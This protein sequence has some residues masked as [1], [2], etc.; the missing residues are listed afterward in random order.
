MKHFKAETHEIDFCKAFVEL[1]T[2]M[3]TKGLPDESGSTAVAVFVS[4]KRIMC[5][6]VGDSRA[7]LIRAGKCVPLSYDHKPDEPAERKR[8]LEAGGHV[9]NN[10]VNGQLAMSR[11]LGDFR[12]KLDEKRGGHEQ[13]VSHIPDVISLDRTKD[14]QFIV[15]AC[16]GIFDVMENDA[17]VQFIVDQAAI[18]PE[19][20]LTAIAEKITRNCLAPVGPTG[21][22]TRGVGTDNMT[23]IITKLLQ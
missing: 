5:G 15:V 10:R 19:Q 11:A 4:P 14:D 1:D 16:D 3:R 8:I 6:S 17:V 18:S 2:A 23:I 21:Q 20:E 9:E 22:P 12:Y 13:L 7:L